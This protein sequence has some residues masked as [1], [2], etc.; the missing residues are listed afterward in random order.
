MPPAQSVGAH[1]RAC[2]PSPVPRHPKMSIFLHPLPARASPAASCSLD[3]TGT[4]WQLDLARAVAQPSQTFGSLS[5][6]FTPAGVGCACCRTGQ[7]R[8]RSRCAHACVMQSMPAKCRTITSSFLTPVEQA[9]PDCNSFH[10]SHMQISLRAAKISMS[11][12]QLK[13]SC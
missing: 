5:Q 7:R 12:E 2:P 1:A 13:Y 11:L 9:E 6:L 4:P 8:V 10:N 3:V